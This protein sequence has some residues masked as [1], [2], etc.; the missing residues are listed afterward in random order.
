MNKTLRLLRMYDAF[1]AAL[2]LGILAAVLTGYCVRSAVHY[3]QMR[4]Q[5]AEYVCRYSGTQQAALADAET[6]D[7]ITAC[8]PQREILL[9]TEH[10]SMTVTLLSVQYLSD[11]YALDPASAGHIIRMNAAAI[12]AAGGEAAESVPLRGTLNGA[13]FSGEGILLSSLPEGA[14]FAVMT[15]TAADLREADCLRVRLKHRDAQAG[16]V[17]SEAGLSPADPAALQAAEYEETLLLVRLRFGLLSAALA[18]I[19][20]GACFRLGRRCAAP[21][22]GQ[23]P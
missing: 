20:A 5:P 7:E 13:D 11:C 19:A 14:P 9:E 15:G 21:G 17:L 2:L 6:C 4:N 1:K 16:A 22:P 3:A 18:L 10:G 12:G 8:S 23:C